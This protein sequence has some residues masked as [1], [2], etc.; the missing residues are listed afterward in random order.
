MSVKIFPGNN[1]WSVLLV[2]ASTYLHSA[3]GFDNVTC[4]VG[5]SPSRNT[6]WTL[7]H[8]DMALG[9][10]SQLYYLTTIP[11]CAAKESDRFEL[12]IDDPIFTGPQKKIPLPIIRNSKGI[13]TFSVVLESTDQM[14]TFLLE[15]L[16]INLAD[17]TAY[18]THK[19]DHKL[20][21]AWYSDG[22]VAAGLPKG[23]DRFYFEWSGMSGKRKTK[24]G[25]TGL[26]YK[27]G[28]KWGIFP[29]YKK[30]YITNVE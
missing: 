5:G 4:R 29:V 19:P 13:V 12:A 27:I 10:K 3:F 14:K 26:R 11:Q 23:N 7:L 16:K 15:Q 28:T 25:I 21:I 8:F 22:F 20:K 9:K 1:N 24:N 17:N 30:F 2:T 18:F 6:Y